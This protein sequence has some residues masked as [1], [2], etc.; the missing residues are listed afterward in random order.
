MLA[1][2]RLTVGHL[3]YN[4]QWE[5]EEHTHVEPKRQQVVQAR[6]THPILP[7]SSSE[8]PALKPNANAISPDDLLDSDAQEA[9]DPDDPL[10]GPR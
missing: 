1:G 10:L 9:L 8:N 6:G 3:H 7:R 2:D 4:V 5:D